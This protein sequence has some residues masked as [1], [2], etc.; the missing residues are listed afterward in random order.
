MGWELL[1]QLQLTFK[2]YVRQIRCFLGDIYDNLYFSDPPEIDVETER[3]HSGINKEAHLTCK[4]QGNPV[5]LVR[6]IEELLFT[7]KQICLEIK[8]NN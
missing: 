4:V 2:F 1:Q 8:Q 6:F 7:D 3:V 5:P